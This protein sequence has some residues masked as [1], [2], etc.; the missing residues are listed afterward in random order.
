MTVDGLA[1]G[2]CPI[3]APAPGPRK[4]VSLRPARIVCT[5]CGV[6]EDCLHPA[7]EAALMD[8]AAPVAP[9]VRLA[10]RDA[11][12]RAGQPF[13]ALYAVRL[14]TFKTV[15]LAEDGRE[16]ITGYH[17]GGAILGL[18]GIGQQRHACDAI[19]L[20]DSEVCPLPY[21]M[22]DELA[23][24]VP[25]LH[26]GL[27]R[28]VCHD[29]RRGQEMI[30]LLGSM[31]AEQRLA[32]FLLDLADRHREH[33]FS[34][35]EFVLRMTREEIASYLGLKLETVSRIFSRLHGEGLIQV[36]GRAIKLIDPVA[37]KHLVGMTG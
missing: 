18:E 28:L 29:L 4:V 5:T 3:A 37:L 23:R 1:R 30:L 26:Q 33:G 10:K 11:L 8:I 21:A 7:L 31:S 16:Q 19:A 35:S 24:R 36:Q 9:P 20:E 32:S 22:L 14:G 13:T 27:L 34:P 6:R 25:A 15:A 2:P 12:F 17:M